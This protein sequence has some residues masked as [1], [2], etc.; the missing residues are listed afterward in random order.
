MEV[1]KEEKDNSE[2]VENMTTNTVDES[3][4]MTDKLIF[5]RKNARQKRMNEDVATI[6]SRQRMTNMTGEDDDGLDNA[7]DSVDL[8]R[9]ARANYLRE[10]NKY[11]VSYG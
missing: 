9:L 3:Y 11:N 5:E 6:L 2:V 4:S 1:L 7:V 8:V 10:L